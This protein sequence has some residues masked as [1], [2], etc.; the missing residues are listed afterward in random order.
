MSL[1]DNT[2]GIK[3]FHGVVYADDSDITNIGNTRG[4][5]RNGTFFLSTHYRL[6]K[7]LF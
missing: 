3:Y 1:K 5:Y 7:K 6:V 4:I 2:Q